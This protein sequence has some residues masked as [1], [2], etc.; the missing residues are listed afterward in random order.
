MHGHTLGQLKL[1]C[2]TGSQSMT[3]ASSIEKILLNV[4]ALEVVAAMSEELPG[5]Q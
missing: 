2:Y 5:S 4:N 3:L 1:T